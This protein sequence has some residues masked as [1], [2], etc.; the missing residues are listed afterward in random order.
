MRTD[1]TIDD[2]DGFLEEPIVAVLATIRQDGF[3]LLSPVWH[4]WRDGGFNVWTSVDDV[5]ARHLRR[6]PKAS[7]VVAESVPPLRGVEV[8]GRATFVDDAQRETA[9]RIAGRYIGSRGTEYVD[10]LP[11]EHAILRLVPGSIRVWDFA[12]DYPPA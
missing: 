5:K 1:I 8:R 7:L 12:D 10:S 9:I 11:G 6:D 4:E 3:V 2:L